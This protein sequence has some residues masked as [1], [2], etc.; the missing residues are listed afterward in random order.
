[1]AFLLVVQT[2]VN[3]WLLTKG[4]AVVHNPE[5]GVHS[6]T[7][8]FDPALSVAA[9]TS[10]W[11][12]LLY[13][14]VVLCLT[15]WRTLRG[16]REASAILPVLLRDGLL[17]Y[18]VIFSVTFVLT[19]M[20]ISAPDGIKNITA[21][22][23]LLITVTMMSRITLNLKKQ[24]DHIALGFDTAVART[25][26]IPNAGIRSFLSLPP[27]PVSFGQVMSTGWIMNAG[28]VQ[29]ELVERQIVD[30]P[31]LDR[32]NTGTSTLTAT[33]TW[34]GKEKEI[35]GEDLLGARNPRPG[36]G[37]SNTTA[38]SAYT[39]KIDA[40]SDETHDGLNTN[41]FYDALG[42]LENGISTS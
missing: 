3:A 10:A 13:D 37:S 35:D 22:L 11:L 4:Q 34:K 32:P 33:S 25:Q 21:Q 42:K 30:R 26:D 18:S 19:I 1:V 5:S 9:S 2:C 23:E 6:C 24:R 28:P 31:N 8:I 40:Q 16:R 7:M 27:L 15:L 38:V 14:T 41:I 20:I 36:T 17:Y 39:S 12:P 29:R